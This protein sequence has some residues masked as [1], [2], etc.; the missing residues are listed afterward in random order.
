MGGGNSNDPMDNLEITSATRIDPLTQARQTQL[1]QQAQDYASQNPF[2]GQYGGMYPGMNRMQTVGQ[3]A[4]ADSILGTGQYGAQNLG[5]TNWSRPQDAAANVDF[6]WEHSGVDPNATNPPPPSGPP[7]SGPPP[8]GPWNPP[9]PPPSGPPGGPPGGGPSVP[10]PIGGGPPPPGGGTQPPKGG[11]TQP[12]PPGG[13]GNINMGGPTQ[14]TMG[15]PTKSP[16]EPVDPALVGPVLPTSMRVGGPYPPMPGPGPGPKP[17]EG[18]PVPPPAPPPPAPPPPAPPVLGPPS[19]PAPAGSLQAGIGMSELADASTA[20]RNLLMQGGPEGVN[21][22]QVTAPTARRAVSRNVADIGATT[23]D[24]SALEEA[25]VGLVDP[26]TGVRS[27]VT[28]P[29]DFDVSTLS[30]VTTQGLDSIDEQQIDAASALGRPE[31]QGIEQYMNQLGVD[32]QLAAAQEDYERQLN[33]LQAQQA[34]SGA[35]SGS[36][37]RL[38]DLGALDQ[39][40]RTRAQI[41]A[42][43]YDRAAER[44]EADLGREQQAALSQAQ[45]SQEARLQQQSIEGQRR[46]ADAEREQQA[47]MQGQQL[48]TEAA[49]QTQRLGTEADLQSQGLSAQASMQQ[50]QLGTDVALQNANNRLQ[51]AQANMQS[52]L[53]RGDRQ[54]VMDAQRNIANAE[55]A[56]EAST[57]NQAAQLQAGGMGLDANARFREQQMNLANQ[58]AGVGGMRQGATFAAAD[59]L[60]GMGRDQRDINLQQQAYDYEQWLQQRRGGAETIDFMGRQLRGGDTFT[61]GQKPDR[62]SQLLGLGATGA[63]FFASDAQMKENIKP[64]GTKNGLNIYEFNYL[65]QPTRW[66]GVIAQEVMKT[67]PD[68]VRERNGV[69]SVNYDALGIAMELV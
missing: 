5:F 23:G 25:N 19:Q 12:P 44:M 60:R 63:S 18:P 53:Q 69:L 28:G 14:P 68:A 26:E 11:G 1:W 67:R 48:D 33:A 56:L 47:R 16:F 10:P 66:R 38:E 22:N 36:R 50:R 58:L 64:V 41:R 59:Q 17:P 3:Q 8:S 65:G 54:A 13:G 29:S 34:G 40:L 2:S 9:T 30:G 51:V 15:G 37:A 49:L 42:A 62:L 7:P 24:A 4:L 55:M 27:L 61:Y 57:R 6:T 45:L 46:Q 35:L 43:G 52:A 39:N 21:Y 31:G 20:T 32:A